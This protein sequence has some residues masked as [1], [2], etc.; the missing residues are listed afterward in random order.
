MLHD[1]VGGG[2]G[3]FLWPSSV[4]EGRSEISNY[5][6]RGVGLVFF[7]HMGGGIRIQIS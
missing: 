5:W 6:S 2:G 1:V 3:Q 7:R 4:G